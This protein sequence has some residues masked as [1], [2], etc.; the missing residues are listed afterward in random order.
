MFRLNVSWIYFGYLQIA[1][2]TRQIIVN[3]QLNCTAECLKANLY[4]LFYIFSVMF[5]SEIQIRSSEKTA[6]RSLFFQTLQFLDLNRHYLIV[7][8]RIWFLLNVFYLII[9]SGTVVPDIRNVISIKPKIANHDCRKI[10][11]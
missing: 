7:I 2:D 6:L 1:E 5:A 11:I 4:F 8:T 10:I 3:I 9:K